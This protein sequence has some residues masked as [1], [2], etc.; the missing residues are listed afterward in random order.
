MEHLP[1]PGGE[2]PAAVPAREPLHHLGHLQEVAAFQPEHI[3]PI[4]VVPVGIHL[5]LQV[6]N[7]PQDPLG[8]IPGEDGAHADGLTGVCGDHHQ[9]VAAGQFQAVIVPDDAI[10]LPFY[11][12]IHNA[13]TVHGMYD[14]I[15]HPEHVI[16]S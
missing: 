4:A 11:D 12:L 9:H 5:D 6:R 3:V 15:S 2:P 10:Y 16:P 8:L 7:L 14:L 1:L 13:G